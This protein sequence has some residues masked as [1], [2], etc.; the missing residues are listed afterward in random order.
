[1]HLS[2]LLGPKLI[3]MYLEPLGLYA[4]GQPPG[5]LVIRSW[6]YTWTLGFLCGC[7]PLLGSDSLKIGQSIMQVLATIGDINPEPKISD[8]HTSQA[9]SI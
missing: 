5:S 2:C 3:I 4:S 7:P 1:M 6:T 9:L 8:C